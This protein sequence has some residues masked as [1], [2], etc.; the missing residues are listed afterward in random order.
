MFESVG[1]TM[2]YFFDAAGFTYFGNLFANQ[3]DARGDIRRRP[4]A[5]AE[6]R[7][8]GGLL[9]SAE[10]VPA[11]PLTVEFSGAPTKP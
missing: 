8:L 4:E 5:L 3:V 2:K 7:R 10:A 1:L 6:A 11:K 9:V